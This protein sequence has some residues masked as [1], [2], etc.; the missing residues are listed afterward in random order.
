MGIRDFPDLFADA[1]RKADAG[2][3]TTCIKRIGPF[4]NEL[5]RIEYAIS[6]MCQECQ[7]KVFKP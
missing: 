5:S 7:D 2:L 4:K 6:G 1:I 3:C